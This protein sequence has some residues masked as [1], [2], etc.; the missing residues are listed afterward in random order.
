MAA[1][2][3]REAPVTSAQPSA[4]RSSAHQSTTTAP[5]VKPAPKAAS[6]T[7]APGCRRPSRSASASAIG[8]SRPR[9]CRSARCSPPR[10]RR[11]GPGARPRRAGSGR[12]PG[13]RRT[14]RCRRGPRRRPR[15]LERRLA[16]ARDGVPVCLL[17]VHP[18]SALVVR[19]ADAVGARAVGAQH[20]GPDAAGP[21]GGHD[22]GAGAV[23]EQ[24]RGAAVVVVD[25]AAHEIGAD[26]EHGVGPAGLDLPGG[27]RQAARNPVHAEPTSSAPARW[28]RA[29]A[30]TSGAAFGSNSSG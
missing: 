2:M 23:A 19:D 4:R 6:S 15:R 5:Q 26:H 18:H 10:A 13:G 27:E 8:T 11:A 12:W 25:H 16:Q 21:A 9:C 22:R 29:R 3:P 7:R 30:A 24:R 28:R 17:A 1:P 20:R 14:G